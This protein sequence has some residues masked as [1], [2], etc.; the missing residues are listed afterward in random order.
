MAQQEFLNAGEIWGMSCA[1]RSC[2]GMFRDFAVTETSET[3]LQAAA[4]ISSSIWNEN[5]QHY[6]AF[7][8]LRA[9]S[10]E[11]DFQITY[12]RLLQ[13]KDSIRIRHT[14]MAIIS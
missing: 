4:A 8:W 11:H 10:V 13:P 5:D 1:C 3:Q 14:N 7:I 2:N 9:Q 6:I 12:Q